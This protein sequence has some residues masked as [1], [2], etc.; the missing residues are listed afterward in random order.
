MNQRIPSPD[1]ADSG[2]SPA[3][4][5]V[6]SAYA[7]NVHDGQLHAAYE[8]TDLEDWSWIILPSQVPS[9]RPADDVMLGFTCRMAKADDR[10]WRV[11]VQAHFRDRGDLP[12]TAVVLLIH[13]PAA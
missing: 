9:D 6:P 8:G 5:T 11:Q 12:G 1:A 7:I 3:P 13:R 2:D 10:H 4:P